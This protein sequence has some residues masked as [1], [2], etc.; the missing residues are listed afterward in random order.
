MIWFAVTL[1]GAAFVA[2]RNVRL[3]R[4]DHGSALRL[5]LCMGGARML[6]LV[7]A[8]HVPGNDEVFLFMSHMAWALYYAGVTYLFYLALEPYARKLWPRMLVS[9]IRLLRGAFSDPLVGRDL[10][11]AAVYGAVA[12]LIRMSSEWSHL[13]F[14]LQGAPLDTGLWS[15]ES[16][17]GLRQAF[18]AVVAL[19]TRS[20]QQTF[21]GITMFLV[22]RLLL[23]KTWLAVGAMS[24]LALVLFNPS[25]GNPWPYLIGFST[26]MALFWIVL[27]RCGLL[28][29]VIG[30]CVESLLI[31]LPLTLDLKAWYAEV[32]LMV[33]L[34]VLGLTAWGFRVAVRGRTLFRDELAEP[35]AA[36][37]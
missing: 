15:I 29:I 27:L 31:E 19:P 25:A 30:G 12:A 1:I 37:G 22:L 3:G 34:L 7:G 36:L 24:L 35:G 16:L 23:R 32:T 21:F 9:W 33:L 20:V 11:I 5:A 14:G 18:T 28:A 13:A 10:L 8:H 2:S 26:G 17:R 6:Y 4:G